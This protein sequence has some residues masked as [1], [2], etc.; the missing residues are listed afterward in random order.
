[1]AISQAQYLLM[2]AEDAREKGDD[3]AAEVRKQA[4]AVRAQGAA[5]YRELDALDQIIDKAKEI[6]RL[7]KSHFAKYLSRDGNDHAAL[8]PT[9]VPQHI[10]K[11]AEK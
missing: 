1:M 4:E 8:P 3:F 7:E 5:H 6:I 10:R 9:G 11:V 2:L